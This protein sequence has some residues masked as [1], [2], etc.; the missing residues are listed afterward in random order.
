MIL[1]DDGLRHLAAEVGIGPRCTAPI[2]RSN[3]PWASSLS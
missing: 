3:G 2:I 1:H